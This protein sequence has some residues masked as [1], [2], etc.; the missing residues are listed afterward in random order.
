MLEGAGPW[1]LQKALWDERALV[2]LWAVTQSLPSLGTAWCLPLEWATLGDGSSCLHSLGGWDR[3]GVWAGQWLSES[4]LVGS[5]GLVAAGTQLLLVAEL[6]STRSTQGMSCGIVPTS[7]HSLGRQRLRQQ[8][9]P[10]LCR[11][12]QGLS[13]GCC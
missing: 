8:Q 4:L 11:Q 1:V 9:E 5:L 6:E 3:A 12:V 2:L 10:V 7:S 13:Q